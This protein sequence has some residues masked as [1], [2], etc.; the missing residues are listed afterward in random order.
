MA[1]LCQCLGVSWHAA[2]TPM[3]AGTVAGRWCHSGFATDEITHS[4]PTTNKSDVSMTAP[5][6]SSISSPPGMNLQ[7]D[8]DCHMCTFIHIGHYSILTV[9]LITY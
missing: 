1:E 3:P 9:D 8:Y 5:L 6:P 2:T 4:F 7:T